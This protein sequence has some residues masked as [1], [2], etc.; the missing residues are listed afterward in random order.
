MVLWPNTSLPQ[1]GSSIGLSAFA[2]LTG[3]RAQHACIHRR[4]TDHNTEHRSP[5]V[6]YYILYVSNW[7]STCTSCRKPTPPSAECHANPTQFC[8][9]S[10]NWAY[11][12]GCHG[13]IPSESEKLTPERSSH[14]ST[15][16]ENLA[17]IGPVDLNIIDLR[18]IVKNKEINK[19]QRQNIS[20]P[21]AAA[22]VGLIGLKRRFKA[23]FFDLFYHAPKKF[24][25]KKVMS[26]N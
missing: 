3:V 18:E 14:S 16:R 20:P 4:H 19:K 6:R 25:V 22:A 10:L 12:I 17:K 8:G 24:F 26:H 15:N 1:N 9:L 7:C 23:W 13:N 11:K 21:A 2:A 5:N